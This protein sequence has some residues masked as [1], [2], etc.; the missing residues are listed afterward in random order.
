MVEAALV[1]SLL[2]GLTILGLTVGWFRIKPWKHDAP[3]T[4][5][6]SVVIPVRNEEENIESLLD[7]L[8]GQNYP[9]ELY[10]VIVVDDG[11]TDGTKDIVERYRCRMPDA[12]TSLST[13]AGCRIRIEESNGEGKKAAIRMGVKIAQGKVIVT[14][15]G[16]C[17]V[18]PE[19]LMNIAAYYEEYKPR[20]ISGPVVMEETRGLFR[21]FQSMEFMSLVASGAGSIGIGMPIMCNG[22]NLAFEK[23]AYLQA[24]NE[25]DLEYASG[26]DIFLMLRIKK[27]FGRHS[28]RF[29]KNREALVETSTKGS[30]RSYLGQRLRWVSKSRGYRDPV[31]ISVALIVFLFNLLLILCSVMAHQSLELSRITAAMWLGKVVID[32]PLILGFSMFAKRDGIMGYYLIF[33][34]CYVL[35]A[36]VMGILGNLPFGYYWKGRKVRN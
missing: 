27:M 19:W 15:D 22:A 3:A 8:V 7:D 33:S 29:L 24:S 20:L 11:S 25:K 34:I 6:L 4:T 9:F 30:L 16:D 5:R 31:I 14:T 36:A 2:Y 17:R 26:D 23:E 12:S 10:E 18:G 32:L 1:A 13:G 35:F 28:I 21:S